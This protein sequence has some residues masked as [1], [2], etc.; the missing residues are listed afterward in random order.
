MAKN[1][2][3]FFQRLKQV[4]TGTAPPVAPPVDDTENSA[5]IGDAQIQEAETLLQKYKQSKASQEARV[6]E[7]EEWY[8]LRQWDY[9]RK[10]NPN[11]GDPEPVSAWAFNAI[12]NKHADAM[13]NFPQPCALPR[14]EM[15]KQ[16][17]EA[18]SDVLP[19]I[20]DQCE[21]EQTY[22]NAW[23]S[24]LK[25]GTG[26]YFV[27]W[28]KS[29]YNGLG[30]VD[31][32][33]IDV[34]NIFWEPGI[35]DIQDSR[36]VFVVALKD[37]D[38]VEDEFPHVKGNLL[39]SAL[40]I[41]KYVNDDTVDTSSKAIVVDWYYKKRVGST[42]VLHYCKFCNGNVLYA[43][44]NDPELKERGWYDDAVMPGRYP[45]E[46]DI[47][48]PQKGTPLGFGIIDIVRSPQMYIDK[49]DQSILK[50]AIMGARPRFFVKGDGNINEEEYAKLENDFVHYTGNGNPNESIMQIKPPLLNAIYESIRINKIDE[51]KETVGNRDFQ[52]GGTAGG[53]TAASGIAALIE[54]GSKTSRDQNGG[55]Y[56][57]YKQICFMVIERIRQ[58]YTENRFF[59]IK[60]QMGEMN[61]VAYNN[62]RIA[63]Q[64]QGADFGVDTGSRVP[65]FDID[66]VP[67]RKSPF[68]V[69]AQNERAK[70]FYSAGFFNPQMADQALACLEMMDFEGI[71]SVRKR[72]QQNGTMY[73]MIQQIAPLMLMMAQSLDQMRGTQYTPQVVQMLG[74]FAPQMP[75]G[76]DAKGEVMTNV[77]GIPTAQ[78]PSP[79]TGQ[80]ARLKA[81]RASAPT[82]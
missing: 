51:L 57:S 32:K 15:D 80:S 17:A 9:F 78:N 29:K 21:F 20:L 68:S 31:I 44:E 42:T 47:L 40:E 38:L 79:G 27:P 73:Q 48:W 67:Q 49:L 36:N 43:T 69:V 1:D 45:F 22:S 33:E 3:G 50:N 56:R 52:Q 71:E 64:P 46:F 24:K 59:R 74:S 7:N 10:A 70:E 58:F 12:I 16:D 65:I 2:I 34:L 26:I 18:L 72:I 41:G 55:S 76:G 5:V 82:V 6:I 13:D 30:D 63:V 53:V 81:A 28:N 75:S 4:I 14:E 61:F 35:E 66:I 39:T 77:L 25:H 19:V 11:K 37:K 62:S 23:W 8:R 54:T 60:G